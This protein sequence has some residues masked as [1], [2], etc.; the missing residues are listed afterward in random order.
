MFPASATL[1]LDALLRQQACAGWPMA[2]PATGRPGKETDGSGGR[3]WSRRTPSE[4]LA[5][6][7]IRLMIATATLRLRRP[8]RVLPRTQPTTDNRQPMTARRAR[9]VRRMSRGGPALREIR[10]GRGASRSG[11]LSRPHGA[12]RRAAEHGNRT[13]AGRP[14]GESTGRS[15]WPKVARTAGSNAVYLRARCVDRGPRT[16]PARSPPAQ[17]LLRQGD[18]G[19]VD[20]VDV[21]AARPDERLSASGRRVGS[22]A[23]HGT[24]CPVPVAVAQVRGPAPWSRVSMMRAASVSVSVSES[25]GLPCRDS[26]SSA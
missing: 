1:R 14:W 20:V 26:P 18:H 7:V 21:E 22:G 23:D 3:R 4:G 17:D 24:A 8:H 19:R 11:E 15:L 9:L 6:Q 13:A 5:E 12:A 10:I 25:S 16:C 2:P